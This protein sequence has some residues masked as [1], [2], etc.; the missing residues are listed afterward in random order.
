MRTPN[1]RFITLLMKARRTGP[2]REARSKP[3]AKR[4]GRLR[5][6][7]ASH[8]FSGAERLASAGDHPGGR[9]VAFEQSEFS[10]QRINTS[11]NKERGSLPGQRWAVQRLPPLCVHRIVAPRINCPT[12]GVPAVQRSGLLA[13]SSRAA[14]RGI[15]AKCHRVA[16]GDGNGS[17]EPF[18][19]NLKKR[20]RSVLSDDFD[21]TG[22]RQNPN[23]AEATVTMGGRKVRNHTS[24]AC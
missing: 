22:T 16:Y 8:V 7:F 4:V 23:R 5:V 3:G 19:Q 6:A 21:Y 20:S 1:A 10:R 12:T 13:N 24:P 14:L 17:D 11:T 2:A 15:E 18:E 9:R